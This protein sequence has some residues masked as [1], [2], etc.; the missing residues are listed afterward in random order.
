MAA[1]VLA[2]AAAT[3]EVLPPLAFHHPATA[4][5]I[6]ALAETLASQ[7]ATPLRVVDAS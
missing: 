1:S 5:F 2:A 6:K 3:Q 4:D 7:G